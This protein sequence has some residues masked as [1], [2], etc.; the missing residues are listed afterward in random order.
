MQ[1]TSKTAI[2]DASEMSSLI[3]SL[4]ACAVFAQQTIDNYRDVLIL[5]SE[6]NF[7]KQAILVSCFDIQDRVRAAMSPELS[8][9]ELVSICQHIEELV[10]FWQM[11]ENALINRIKN[12][13]ELN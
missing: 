9:L 2:E 12:I 3:S 1:A 7:L 8:Q 11:S 5:D 4:S 13:A 10:Y 6:A